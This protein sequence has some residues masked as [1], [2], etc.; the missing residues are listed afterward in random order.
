MEL[1]HTVRVEREIRIVNTKVKTLKIVIKNEKSVK[2]A[3]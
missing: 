2:K 3:S 1:I